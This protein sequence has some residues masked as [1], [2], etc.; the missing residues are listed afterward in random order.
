[1][2]FQESITYINII[3]IYVIRRFLVCHIQNDTRMVI[4]KYR[5]KQQY[6]DIHLENKQNR[7]INIENQ[8]YRYMTDI[9][10][11]GTYIF[12]ENI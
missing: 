12:K 9:F 10:F 7:K 6:I 3:G 2:Q 8:R 4:Y 1:M 11:S 5:G